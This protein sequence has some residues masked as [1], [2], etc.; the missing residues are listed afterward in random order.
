LSASSHK[1]RLLQWL[2]NPLAAIALAL[3]LYALAMSLP[4]SHGAADGYST[5][6]RWLGREAIPTVSFGLHEFFVDFS[7]DPPVFIDLRDT[8]LTI[9][10]V[11]PVDDR[12]AEL[13]VRARHSPDRRFRSGFWAITREI[14]TTTIT[15]FEL[16]PT[17][18]VTSEDAGVVRAL[19]V[20]ALWPD[21]G[22][23]VD[24]VA[25]ATLRRS[26]GMY[27]ARDESTR[28]VWSGYFQDAVAMAVFGALLY[29]LSSMRQWPAWIRSVTNRRA[30]RL[31]R[32]ICPACGYDLTGLR[33][34]VCPEC[35]ERLDEPA[36]PDR[37]ADS[38]SESV[39]E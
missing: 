13:C 36:D 2:R 19:I 25:I 9:D 14:T 15:I 26:M 30:A 28:I 33:E 23:A 31:A 18:E 34:P 29:S 39:V 3:L 37:A 8:D 21:W 38:A 27:C 4:C 16:S 1:L 20:E 6:G 11:W 5:V 35:G 32:G 17:S 7:S 12:H 10:D 24:G 22:S